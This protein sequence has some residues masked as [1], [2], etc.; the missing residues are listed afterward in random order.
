MRQSRRATGESELAGIHFR[1]R[2]PAARELVGR[3]RVIRSRAALP[4]EH[5]TQR[6]RVLR[7]ARALYCRAI[8]ARK[9]LLV[10][11]R[12]PRRRYHSFAATRR[13]LQTGVR[14]RVQPRQSRHTAPHLLRHALRDAP[15]AHTRDFPSGWTGMSQ[16]DFPHA[17][18]FA[19]CSRFGN[20]VSTGAV[21]RRDA[22]RRPE[23]RRA[24]RS[25]WAESYHFARP[26]QGARV[27]TAEITP[28]STPQGSGAS[29]PSF[30]TQRPILT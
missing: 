24:T 10:G 6:R 11:R 26:P 22:G 14:R 7:R 21:T 9:F 28:G 29:V 5:P 12:P 4:F 27:T 2:H 8:R 3:R 23:K 20:P 13:R 17:A 1:V 25:Q 19:I 30:P 18:G 15:H 16:C